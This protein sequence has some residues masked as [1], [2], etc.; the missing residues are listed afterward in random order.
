MES[1]VFIGF[2][3]FIP[4]NLSKSIRGENFYTFLSEHDFYYASV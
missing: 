1:C 3:Y 2:E 4:D